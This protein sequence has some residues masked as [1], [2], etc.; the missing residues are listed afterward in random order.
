M[1]EAK[2]QLS[3]NKPAVLTVAFCL[4]TILFWQF[5]VFATVTFLL[6]LRQNRLL[7]SQKGMVAARWA[8]GVLLASFLFTVV[9]IARIDVPNYY[10]SYRLTNT[11]NAIKSVRQIRESLA[12]FERREKGYPGTLRELVESGL[13][14]A[15]DGSGVRSGFNFAY[16]PK[17]LMKGAGDAAKRYSGFSLT[18]TPQAF[19]KGTTAIFLDESG[20]IVFLEPP[21]Q[22]VRITHVESPPPLWRVPTGF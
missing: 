8:F 21:C 20:F 13:L 18:A 6:A 22:T 10:E 19:Y 1:E 16:L 15:E 3:W 2:Q 12:K 7:P 9:S 17:G 11:D 5:I 4:V 14:A